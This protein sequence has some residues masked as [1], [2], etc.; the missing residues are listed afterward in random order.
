MA[1]GA[2]SLLAA[3][4]RPACAARALT[5]LLTPATLAA[6]HRQ[7]NGPSGRLHRDF[8]PGRSLRAEVDED[9]AHIRE[10]LRLAATLVPGLRAFQTLAQDPGHGTLKRGRERV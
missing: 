7:H 5:A 3:P 1:P 6:A 2:Y 4:G 10:R 8:S 9:L